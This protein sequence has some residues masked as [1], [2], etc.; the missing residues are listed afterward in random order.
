MEKCDLVKSENLEE[1]PNVG[2]EDN[3]TITI[4]KNYI[5]HLTFLLGNDIFGIP[6]SSIKEVM[7]Y[8]RVFKTPG[9]PAYIRGVINLRGEV[10]PVIDLN[11][12]F[13]NTITIITD[14]T[15]IVVVEVTENN[16][17]TLIGVMV[18]AVNAVTDI[19]EDSIENAPDIGSRVRTDFI[20][21]I[22]KVNDQFIILLNTDT[23]LNIDELSIIDGTS[24]DRK[25]IG[26]TI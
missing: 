15:G 6:V 24:K 21:G 11:Y 25:R 3:E 23:V 20:S 17:V 9:V 26:E 7:E 8:K 19:P 5:L 22:G 16:E 13:Y 12:R 10:V 2:I 1:M 4:S 18:D 14:T